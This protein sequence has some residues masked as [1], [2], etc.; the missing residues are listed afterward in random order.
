[1]EEQDL[2]EAGYDICRVPQEDAESVFSPEIGLLLA[3]LYLP[4][5]EFQHLQSKGKLPKHH[6]TPQ[7]TP[8]LE[9]VVAKR[10]SQYPTSLEQDRALLAAG[11][12][13]PRKAM[14]LAVRI[15]EKEILEAAAALLKTATSKRGGSATESSTNKRRKIA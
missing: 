2:L 7:M 1:M 12:N 15:G 3:L 11:V 4:Y 10:I 14:A 13:E 8:L 6:L 9:Q 5:R